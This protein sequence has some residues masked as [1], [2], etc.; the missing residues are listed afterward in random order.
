M[1]A[2]LK[3]LERQTLHLLVAATDTRDKHLAPTQPLHGREK[4]L[5]C[6][7]VFASPLLL[8]L[9]ERLNITSKYGLSRYENIPKGAQLQGKTPLFYVGQAKRTEYQ[10]SK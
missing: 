1:C 3:A 7:T 2:T 4:H 8:N 6:G 9:M 10:F 5:L